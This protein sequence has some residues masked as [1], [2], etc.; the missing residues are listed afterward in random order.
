MGMFCQ[1]CGA[2]LPHGKNKCP[3]CGRDGSI[4]EQI[5]SE[6]NST[7][8]FPF[9]KIRDG[10]EQFL[11]DSKKAIEKKK[12]LLAQAPTGIGKTAAVLTAAVKARGEEKIFFLT[13]KQSQHY[14]AIETIK[15]M[16]SHVSAM[17]VISKQHMCPRQE[18]KLP[19][20]VFEKFCSSA[21]QHA[22]NLY[23]K[24]MDNVVE[25]LRKQ[26]R[27]V[28]QIMNLCNVQKVCP[29][30]AAL[31][32]ARDA[33]VIVCDYNY[34]FSDISEN[35]FDVLD[36]ELEDTVVIVDE[37]HNLPDRIR[38]NL[39][40]N[41]NIPVLEEAHRLLRGHASDLAG[42]VKRFAHEVKNLEGEERILNKE[43]LDD[44][45]EIAI[46]GGFGRYEN[47]SDML[48]DLDMVARDLLEKDSSASAP[49]RLFS[50]LSQWSHE[51][52]EIFRALESN[53][54]TIKVGLLDPSIMSKDVFDRVSGAVLM[55]G[56]LHPGEMYSDLLGIQEPIIRTYDSPFPEFNRKIV[57]VDHLTTSYKERSLQMYQ[58]YANSIAEVSNRT[59]GNL[60]V[61][62]PSYNLMES[63][64]DRLSMVH[65]E[66]E[67]IIEERSYRKWEKEELVDSLK[68]SNDKVLLGVQ[69]GSLSE[70]VDYKNN[71][72]SS[73]IIVGIPFPPPSLELSALRDYYTQKFGKQKGY[74]YTSVYP[75]LNRVMQA[76]GRSI[77]SKDDRALIVLMDK[78]FNYS[79]YKA[80][81]PESFSYDKSSDL[82]KACRDFFG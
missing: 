19:Y 39:E 80:M 81:F 28:E 42:F 13:S 58:A 53:P 78:R 23:N 43:E 9:K 66:K 79:R 6:E 56:T 14:I 15:K 35:V 8:L 70:G 17:D 48:K 82:S 16:P 68:T 11:E 46:K 5:P 64:S 76:A 52:K 62:F 7:G 30:K 59:P 34:I 72:L 33:D 3:N 75:A 74:E 25:S 45:V 24:K 54:L 36:M 51:G 21:G 77:R 18:S 41:I 22:C 20:P 40:E 47:L 49:M 67:L 27:H 61:F 50:F 31:L 12:T 32:A 57:T 60:A 2:L 63:I 65:L 10:Q 37:A 71:I 44:M 29:H 1:D 26:T 73:V 38:G 4:A 55:S 69:G